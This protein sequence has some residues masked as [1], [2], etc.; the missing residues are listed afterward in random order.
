MLKQVIDK[1][2]FFAGTSRNLLFVTDRRDAKASL[3]LRNQ[4]MVNTLYAFPDGNQVLTGDAMGYLKVWDLR[5]GTCLQEVVN[6]SSQKPISHIAMCP[7][8]G[9]DEVQFDKE[10]KGLFAVNSYDNSKKYLYV[11]IYKISHSFLI[12]IRIYER[13]FNQSIQLQCA[14]KGYINKNWPIKSSF[15]RKREGKSCKKKQ[16]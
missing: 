8:L 10:E 12:V 3:I 14:L 11:L 15:Y 13:D 2:I 16:A 9:A 1:N 7:P 4:A 6:E 5:T